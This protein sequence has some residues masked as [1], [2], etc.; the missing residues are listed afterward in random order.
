MVVLIEFLSPEP[1]IPNDPR[2]LALDS[3]LSDDFVMRQDGHS[4]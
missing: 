2:H 1:P 4:C 3:I